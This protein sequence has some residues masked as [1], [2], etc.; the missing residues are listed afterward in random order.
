MNERFTENATADIITVE[1]ATGYLSFTP[2]WLATA[3][4]TNVKA[5][6][7]ILRENEYRSGNCEAARR[8][9]EAMPTLGS[10]ARTAGDHKR[11]KSV[12]AA[13]SKYNAAA[14]ENRQDRKAAAVINRLFKSK[15][16][17]NRPDY[18]AAWIDAATGKMCA[19][20]GYRLYRFDRAVSGVEI[21]TPADPLD[22]SAAM[23]GMS[24]LT[25]LKPPTAAKLKLHDVL[26]RQN[27]KKSPFDFG[28]GKP[29]AAV[30]FL[31]DL[32]RLFPAG[33]WYYRAATNP[34]RRAIYVIDAAGDALLLPVHKKAEPNPAPVVT[35]SPEQFAERVERSALT[36]EQF[37]ACVAA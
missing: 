4:V 11:V 27:K 13:W 26:D 12:Q 17:E 25:P 34:D 2:E 9:A 29:A 30:D 31:R 22:P 23:G 35:L 8:I 15:S 24:D 1:H 37:A 21:G 16:V 7:K 3:P 28:P 32:L 36:P 10:Y 5:M 6:L 18:Q 20:D 33:K 14:P 19:T